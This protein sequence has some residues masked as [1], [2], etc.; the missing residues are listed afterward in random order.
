MTDAE[1]L[2]EKVKTKQLG[3]EIVE[4]LQA[5]AA[6]KGSKKKL[7]PDLRYKIEHLSKIGNYRQL[8]EDFEKLYYGTASVVLTL[9]FYP[10]DH[11]LDKIVDWFED[12]VGRKVIV[13][14][15]VDPE[16]VGGAKVMCN[17]HF[18]DY[19]VHSKLEEMGV[20]GVSLEAEQK[21]S[22]II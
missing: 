2:F 3:E 22:A 5:L 19:S 15:V 8:L 14:L 10:S 4:A 17:E 21:V 18:R 1:K 12:N 16:I 7:S 6:S 9:A 20:L 11:F 13:D